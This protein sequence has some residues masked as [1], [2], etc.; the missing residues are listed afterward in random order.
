[1]TRIVLLTVAM[2][3]AVLVGVYV[4]VYVAADWLVVRSGPRWR[5]ECAKTG[6]AVRH[7]T[8]YLGYECFVECGAERIPYSRFHGCGVEGKRP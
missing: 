1:M 8:V 3:A 2:C 5:E 6:R 7:P 4:G